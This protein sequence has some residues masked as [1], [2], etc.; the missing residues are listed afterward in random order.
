MQHGYIPRNALT[1]GDR[2]VSE[3]D[4]SEEVGGKEQ[5]L[6]ADPFFLAFPI[7]YGI[8]GAFILSWLPWL[9]EAYNYLRGARSPIDQTALALL[10]S[11]G[12]RLVI[13]VS[14]IVG[15][16]VGL[17]VSRV[18]TTKFDMMRTKGDIEIGRAY[19]ALICGWTLFYLPIVIFTHVY[20]DSRFMFDIG[21]YTLAGY[22]IALAVPVLL[23]YI[24]LLLYARSANSHIELVGL[25]NGSDT[26]RKS[27]GLNLRVV[28]NDLE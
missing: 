9:I 20:T 28:R 12:A 14:C 8:L 19:Y 4:S 10:G 25:S 24:Q 2:M 21:F 26:K 1:S 3:C 13:I 6:Q 15:A 18:V 23:K 5:S 22:F 27:L 11:D 16:V 7:L 17:V